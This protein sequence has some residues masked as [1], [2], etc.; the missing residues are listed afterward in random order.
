MKTMSVFWLV[1]CLLVSPVSALA[2][3]AEYPKFA[4][5]AATEYTTGTYGGD[6]DIEDIY[7]P[8][9]GLVDMRRFSLKLTVPYL[10]VRAPEGTVVI[11]PGGEPIP[12]TGDVRTNSG[13]GDIIASATVYDVVYSR[14]LNFA[15]DIN[16]RVKFGTADAEKGLGT[17]E[18]DYSIR[19]DF[20]KF[21]DRLT[22]IGSV[23]YKFR[24]DTAETN[25]ENVVT[26]SIGGMYKFSPALK[27]GLFFD[28]REP[29]ISGNESIQELS[30]LLS[31]RVGENW[32][33]QVYVMA[34]LTDTSLDW[35]TGIQMKRYLAARRD[36]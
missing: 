1:G 28:Y 31:T 6:E 29:T 16:G 22:L 34:G 36:D 35:G 10:S 8:L 33:L 15:I 17:G 23:G 32:R 26:G 25:F 4:F 2:A 19:A 18:N 3:G 9:S 21:G 24:G 14:R 7:V 12:G 30:A 13:L 11:G 5:M 27:G 20:L